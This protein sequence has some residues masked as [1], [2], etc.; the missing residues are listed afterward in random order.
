MRSAGRGVIFQEAVIMRAVFHATLFALA[1][2]TGPA[3]HAQSADEPLDDEIGFDQPLSADERSKLT[4]VLER[5]PAAGMSPAQLADF[6]WDQNR[7]AMRLGDV[8]KDLELLPKWLASAG[9][10]VK[11]QMRPT[12]LL[13]RAHMRGGD[14]AQGIAYAERLLPLLPADNPIYRIR[15]LASLAKNY[16]DLMNL[17]RADELLQTA[18]AEFELEKRRP[19][20]PRREFF[21]T[22]A[23]SAILSARNWILSRRGKHAEA[24]A[25]A[26]EALAVAGKMM[27]LQRHVD[28]REAGESPRM[29]ALQ[30]HEELMNSQINQG[31]LIDAA[32]TA[33]AMLRFCR[34]QQIGGNDLNG[35]YLRI[36]SLKL[37][38]N[39]MRRA[40]F[41][42]RAVFKQ[43]A[44]AQYFNKPIIAAHQRLMD[45]LL[46]KR[47]WPEALA[48]QNQLDKGVEGNAVMTRIALRPPVR[49][50]ILAYNGQPGQSQ[51]L[52]KR[53]A[54]IHAAQFGA[55]HIDTVLAN[56]LY[57]IALAKGGQKE[58]A[59]PLFAS[60]MRDLHAPDIVGGEVSD[61]GLQRSFR[62]LILEEY[63]ALLAERASD[64]A[65]IDEAF[66]ATEY[67]RGSVVEQSVVDSAV[68]AAAGIS[69]LGEL[70][71]AQQ[72]MQNEM[73]VLQSFLAHQL[74]EPPQR[75]LPGVVEQV[76]KRMA[77]LQAEL[78]GR[79]REITARFPEYDA[80]IHPQPPSIAALGKRLGPNEAFIGIVPTSTRVAV[81]AVSAQGSAFTI[82]DISPA[83]LAE[84]V[85]RLRATLDIGDQ[86]PGSAPRYDAD[87]AYRIYEVLLAPVAPIWKGKSQLSIAAGG[88]VGQIPF[89]VL[90]TAP[91]ERGVKIDDA[92]LRKA[93]WLVTQ[94]AI[95][96]VP[97]A[98]SWAALRDAAR[99]VKAGQGASKPFFGFGDPL[100]SSAQTTQAGVSKAGAVR[101]VAVTR[102]AGGGDA[103]LISSAQYDR[104]PPLPETRDEIVA[105]ATALGADPQRDAVF[106]REASRKN[107]IAADLSKHRVIVFATHGLVAGDLPNLSQPALALAATGNDAES[108][109]LTLE[110]VLKLKLDADW[111][112]LSAC[113][114]AAADGQAGEAIS[115]LGRGFFYAG[116]KSLLVTHWAV[117]TQSA[118]E[119]TTATFRRFGADPALPRAEALRQAQ[120]GMIG[121]KDHA[122]P[123]YW[124]PYALIGDGGR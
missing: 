123:F 73:S 42:A 74:S 17:A 22:R 88:P 21:R 28:P 23:E 98:S 10:D 64:P 99:L 77:T 121:S 75:Q 117:E 76:R 100:F 118:M 49:G 66:R 36:S 45:L 89:A 109:L 37:A 33:Q 70:V 106:G 27:E 68:R 46:I 24:E 111:I 83:Q 104:L 101:K 113:N 95:S 122:H 72:D 1:M 55:R 63:I 16:A 9:S 35:P 114:T 50:L 81:L 107:V 116:A 65:A 38:Q 7:A 53:N 119:L 90:L 30:A 47:A 3:L 20:R 6:Y 102:G 82:A 57:A 32:V 25:V 112:V 29:S 86:R 92:W 5:Q 18:Q 34:E 43:T 54:E 84:L 91:A 79:H 41:Y 61:Q 97:S 12:W 59:L 62:Q 58:T 26:R 93:P 71:R 51:N 103:D 39:D 48:M 8:A 94:A 105:I 124:A 115:G 87:A 108:P 96:H 67:L 31:H 78:A 4:A 56:G 69:G 11:L 110:D 2:L 19:S 13:W 60:A 85:K 80:L 52:L 14:V 44:G 15:M 120:L 40:E